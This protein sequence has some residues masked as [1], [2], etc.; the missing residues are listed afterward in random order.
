MQ[1]FIMRHGQASF[2]APSD[3]ARE[4]TAQGRQESLL[5]AQWLSSQ[6]S[7]PLDVVLHSPYRR[8]VQTWQHI[9]AH[10]PSQQVLVC[11]EA[12]PEGDVDFVA[13][14]LTA[15][16]EQHASVLLVSHLPLVGYLLQDLCHLPHAPMFAT[17]AIAAI[18]WRVTDHGFGH[19]ELLWLQ[20]PHKVR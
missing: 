17:S 9:S 10:L 13:S 14:Y 1:L 5:M 12:T 7:A 6:L 18:D 20:S 4:L 3:A 15:L 11:N 16:A 19:G 2:Q 8:A